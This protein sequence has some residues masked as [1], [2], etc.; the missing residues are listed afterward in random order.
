MSGWRWFTAALAVALVGVAAGVAQAGRIPMVRTA[1]Q[2]NHGTRPDQTVPYLTNGDSGFG[3][4]SIGPK[5]SSSP[6]VDDPKNPQAKPVYTIIFYGSVQGFG[7]KNN[8]A[9]ERSTPVTP[10]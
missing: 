5:V 6:Q 9:V 4:Y 2:R 7:G 10:R 1:G 8:G 3:A